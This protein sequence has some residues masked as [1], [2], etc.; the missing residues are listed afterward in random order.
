MP[1]VRS[2][3]GGLMIPK[4]GP[5]LARACSRASCTIHSDA[6]TSI[7]CSSPDNEHCIISF[8]EGSITVVAPSSVAETDAPKLYSQATTM[9]STTSQSSACKSMKSLPTSTTMGTTSAVASMPTLSVAPPASSSNDALA[10]DATSTPAASLDA[11]AA[12]AESERMKC[13]QTATTMGTASA[14][15]STPTLSVAPP[16]SSSNMKKV[17]GRV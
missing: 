17:V 10:I 2:S 12:C 9:P 5:Q 13:L 15:P 3:I 4:P 14:A 6:C 16:P 11:L 7:I 8:V 1:T